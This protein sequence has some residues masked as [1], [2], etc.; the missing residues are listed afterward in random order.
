VGY[1]SSALPGVPWDERRSIV[2]NIG[3]RVVARAGADVDPGC[4]DNN[5]R[6]YVTGWLKR[7]PTG[8]IASAVGDAKETAQAVLRDLEHLPH[9][10]T[11]PDPAA[12]LPCLAE[13]GSV[14]GAGAGAGAVS[15]GQFLII[16]ERERA[17]GQ[18]LSPAKPREKLTSV[19]EMMEIA[20]KR[21]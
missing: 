13:A 16:D 7:G 20:R 6:L 19:G 14:A 5:G 3:G 17:A 12:I 18:S 15:W 9:A 10:A 4:A 1:R 11:R 2:P 21:S 8:I